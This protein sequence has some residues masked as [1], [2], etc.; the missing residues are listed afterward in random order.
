MPWTCMVVC[1]DTELCHRGS[2]G[3]CA[4]PG[5]LDMG[6]GLARRVGKA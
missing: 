3:A 2:L 4:L 5:A 6:W 1:M